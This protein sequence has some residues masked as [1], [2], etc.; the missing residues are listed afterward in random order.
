MRPQ[1][2]QRSPTE[3]FRALLRRIETVIR[4]LGGRNL[5][6]DAEIVNIVTGMLADP[7][8]QRVRHWSR[9][10]VTGTVTS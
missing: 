4:Q 9:S 7:W 2:M 1:P 3:A 10:T 8:V 6:P 5:G